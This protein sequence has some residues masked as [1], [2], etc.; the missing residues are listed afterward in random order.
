[1]FTLFALLKDHDPRIMRFALD[2]NVQQELTLYLGLQEIEFRRGKSEIE[3]DGQYK[4]DADEVLFIPRFDDAYGVRR[5]VQN[6]LAI[7]IIDPTPEVFGKISALF[8]GRSRGGVTTVLL[9]NFDKRK[10]MSTDGFSL[11]HSRNV[12][13][14][15]D[16]IGLTVDWK[17]SAILDEQK[18]SF[19]SF[20]N[21]RQFFDLTSHYIEA[22]NEDIQA[23]AKIP[24]VHVSDI[25]QLISL[26]DG[27]IRRKFSMVQ[28]SRVLE[29][30]TATD[31]SAA[32]KEFR[33]PLNFQ[34]DGTGA[35]VLHLPLDKKELKDLLRFLDEDFYRSSLLKNHYVTN[36][37]REINRI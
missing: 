37:K 22:T 26:S 32:A 3:F 4:P 15:I 23:F 30:V 19:L 27:W 2:L 29:K 33:I 20:H 9:Q 7:P 6:P 25:D 10:V 21:T 17:L 1:M 35:Q 24:G 28:Q 11:F 12:F 5:A 34:A 18:L 8:V 16:G 36:S 14:K 31:M 13:K